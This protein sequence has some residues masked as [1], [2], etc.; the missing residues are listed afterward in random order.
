MPEPA[1]VGTSGSAAQEPDASYDPVTGVWCDL[2]VT[3]DSEPAYDATSGIWCDLPEGPNRDGGAQG[4][5]T[6]RST[7]K[8][9]LQTMIKQAKGLG[10]GELLSRLRVAKHECGRVHVIV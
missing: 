6:S 2:T 10:D 3:E 5:E 4:C 8:Q 1:S 9:V 7:E